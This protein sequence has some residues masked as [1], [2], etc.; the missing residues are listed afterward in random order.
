[1]YQYLGALADAGIDV[2]TAPLFTDADLDRRY[3]TGGYGWR[4]IGAAT[5]GRLRAL[6][7]RQRY[8]ALW[9][10]YELLPF[11]PALVEHL[12]AAGG[13]PRVVEYD[14]AVFH[15]YDQHPSAWVRGLLGGKI[16]R[17]M[18]AAAVVVAG[19]AYLADRARA[20]GA[21]EVVTIPSV[22]DL[23]AYP[24]VAAPV[25]TPPV[26]GWI[27]S[28][29]TAAALDAVTGALAQV[30]AGDRARVVLVGVEPG[31]RS[32]PFPCEERPWIEGREAAD[33]AGFDV[34]IMPLPDDPWSR[35][36]CG[37][38]LVQYLACG[39]PAV[40]SPV[41]ANRDIVVPEVT[42]LLASTPDEWVAALDRLIADPAL[43]A[44]LGRAGRARVE[45]HYALQR[46]APVVADVLRRVATGGLTTCAA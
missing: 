32:W 18:R 36:K 45:A 28:P 21:R 38:K 41:G 34:G 24:V 7:T 16:D 29:S 35:G 19:N 23:D 25:V 26:I 39:R 4:A 3:A 17:V 10:E 30:C 13:P 44:R 22:V 20:A 40:A 9:I 43:R 1:M 2:T 46:T 33:I 15:R 12:L 5:A 27:G 31:R 11:A 14:D 8:D 6:A 37:Y 42:G